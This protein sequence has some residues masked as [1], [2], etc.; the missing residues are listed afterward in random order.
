MRACKH[1]ETIDPETAAAPEWK[2][3]L[4]RVCWLY[5]HDP[6]YKALYDGTANGT[7]PEYDACKRPPRDCPLRR[8]VMDGDRQKARACG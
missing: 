5:L 3:G 6:Q 4:C 8:P 2:P 1:S 7:H